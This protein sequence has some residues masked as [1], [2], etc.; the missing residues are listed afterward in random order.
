[1]IFNDEATYMP[2]LA[3]KDQSGPLAPGP[4]NKPR[5]TTP[6]PSRPQPK[7]VTISEP[8][9]KEAFGLYLDYM[10]DAPHGT[11]KVKTWS[12]SFGNFDFTLEQD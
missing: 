5:E 9:A 3:G 8:Q 1:M 11:Y 6:A 10:F 7:N 12:T 2:T 4:R